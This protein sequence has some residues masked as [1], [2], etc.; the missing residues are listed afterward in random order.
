M[1]TCWKTPGRTRGPAGSACGASHPDRAGQAV[2]A[3]IA[4]PVRVLGVGQVL[5]VV[6]LG[7][8]VRVQLADL[9][10]DRTVPGSLY[11]RRERL[12]RRQRLGELPVGRGVDRRPVLAADVVALS[13]ALGRVVVLPEHLE[14]VGEGYPGRVVHDLDD[15]G[16]PGVAGADLLVRGVRRVPAGVPDRRGDH[17]GDAPE[18]L[19]GTPETAPAEDDEPGALQPRAGARRVQDDVAG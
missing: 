5:L 14:Q 9:R 13:H 4:V 7:V 8:V 6:V 19:L 10:G 11:H 3:V 17:A 2:G 15:L 16:M 1:T 12:T 18:H